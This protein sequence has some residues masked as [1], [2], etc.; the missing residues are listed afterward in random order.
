MGPGTINAM[1][2]VSFHSVLYEEFLTLVCC[3]GLVD[4]DLDSW[5]GRTVST[6]EFDCGRLSSSGSSNVDLEASGIKLCAADTT[7]RVQR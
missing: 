2:S 7:R 6:R 1:A 5:V 4:V 3:K